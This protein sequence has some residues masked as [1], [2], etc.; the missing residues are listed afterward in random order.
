MMRENQ[1]IQIYPN[2][3]NDVVNIET[4][5]EMLSVLVVNSKGQVV[6]SENGI[7]SNAYQINIANQP[8]GIFNVRIETEEGWINRKLVKK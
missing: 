2:P 5:F 1:N 3:V 4:D 8:S 6:W 7:K